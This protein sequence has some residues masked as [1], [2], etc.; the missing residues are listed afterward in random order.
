[1]SGAVPM[2]KQNPTMRIAEA[3]AALLA[4]PLLLVAPLLSGTFQV[5]QHGSGLL[6]HPGICQD[7]T[8]APTQHV[9]EPGHRHHG[10]H[11]H[12]HHQHADDPGESGATGNGG[13]PKGCFVIVLHRTTIAPAPRLAVATQTPES[14][15]PSLDLHPESDGRRPPPATCQRIE[16]AL[17]RTGTEALLLSSHA[18]LI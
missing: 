7:G 13:E 17:P 6:V 5:H 12:G 18:L 8:T 2:K 3:V 15:A 9:S 10:H 1:M 11:G 16:R 14:H 4:L